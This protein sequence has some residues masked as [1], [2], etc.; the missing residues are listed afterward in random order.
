MDVDQM[1]L[2]G[3]KQRGLAD[4]PLYA[5]LC[6]ALAG[7]GIVE[8]GCKKPPEPAGIPK[9][10][11]ATIVYTQIDPATAGSVSGNVNFKGK[12]PERILIDMAQDPVCGLADTNLSE[13]YM[14]RDGRVKNVF[15]YVKDGLGNKVYAAP[16]SPVNLDQKGCRFAPH[17]IAVMAG[18]PVEFTNSDATTHNVDLMPK[19]DHN[20]TGDISQP[21]RSGTTQRTF[22]QPETMIPVRCNLHPWMEAFINVSANPFYAVTDDSGH[23]ELKGLPPGTYT[24]VAVHEKLGQQ[25]MQITVTPHAAAPAEFSFSN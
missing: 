24:V 16:S 10:A 2:V 14:V 11:A 17:T 7:L 20:Q 5:L 19:M 23:F 25:T 18:Q 22:A 4:A 12:A 6:V 15:V 21:P 13:Q 8:A 3:I 9:P 1:T